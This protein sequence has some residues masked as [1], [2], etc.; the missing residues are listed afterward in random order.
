ML[1]A[2]R[3][4]A[5]LSDAERSLVIETALL[6]AVIRLGLV[7]GSVQRVR[8]LL[9]A[10]ARRPATPQRLDADDVVIIRWAVAAVARRIHGCTCL[11]QAL[12]ADALLAR[13]GFAPEVCFGV[14]M[15]PA[16]SPRF[17]AHAWVRC[18]EHIVIGATEGGSEFT[19]MSRFT[20]ARDTL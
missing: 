8:R 10:C 2:Y 6:M 1:A 14:R 13:R 15:D 19:E 5:A 18:D 4:Y 17:E 9:S 11:V 12:T 16:R 3:R 20:S 7:G